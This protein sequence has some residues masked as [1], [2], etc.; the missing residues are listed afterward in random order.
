MLF[1]LFSMNNVYA[2][3]EYK[4]TLEKQEGIYYARS[5]GDLPYKSSQFSLYKLNDILAYCIEPSKNITTY[6][7]VQED[8][9]IDLG[10]SEELKEKLELIGYYGREYPNHDNVRYSMATQALI[11]ELTGKQKVTFWTKRYEEGDLI[12]VSKEKEEIMTLVN[13][14]QS[15]PNLL[16]EVTGFWQKEI[17]LEDQ[18][19]LL[20][21]FEI[22]DTGGHDVFIEENKLHILPQKVGE[23]SLQLRRKHY[24]EYQTLLFV[25][26]DKDTSQT[27]GRLR[28]TKEITFS[29]N[30]KIY[31]NKI[32]VNKV[33]EKGKNILQ[34][35]IK[36]Q[37]KDLDSNKNL[38]ENNLCLFETDS[39]GSFITQ[40]YY[41]G[42]YE[43][44]ELENQIVNGYIWNNQVI[45][46]DMSKE[47]KQYQED[48]GNYNE[49]NFVNESVLGKIE[50]HK[51]GEKC[52]YL[53]N[54]IIYDKEDLSDIEFDLYD[55]ENHFIVTL[56]T[57]KEGKASYDNL[58][59]GTYYLVEKTHLD[60]YLLNEDKYYF[61]LK[62][63]NQ[64]EKEVYVLVEIT[65]YLKKGHLE[66]TKEDL[67]TG[68]GIPNTIIEIYNEKGE[69]LFIKE[70][71]EEGKVYLSDLPIGKY[72]IIEKEANSLYRLTNEKVFFEIRENNEITKALMTNEK[73]VIS[74][75][76]TGRDDNYY[77]N[78]FAIFLIILGISGIIYEKKRNN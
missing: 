5:G 2:Q 17:I 47:N 40:N 52:K 65:N 25:G 24:D 7:Y 61:T 42:R 33:D 68:E 44:S 53:D 19:N 14:H 11:W 60:D 62:Q 56:K 28:F 63:N 58:P 16:K 77:V 59:L 9:Y 70:T 72:Y 10:Y 3:T 51:V 21:D 49:I 18:D 4:L 1:F 30:L 23:T 55:E 66:F 20:K 26:S 29:I 12:D 67:T 15:V 39:S 6:N 22:I 48:I 73:I 35:G 8:G 75:P 41:F 31:G 57:N 64:Y 38:C 34:K 36:F 32:K 27:L 50:I 76:K 78:F 13:N 74:V 45:E 43:I 71:N 69:L 54:E 37:I 46:I